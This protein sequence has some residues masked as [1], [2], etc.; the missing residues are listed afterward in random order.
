MLADRCYLRVAWLARDQPRDSGRSGD[1]G[2]GGRAVLRSPRAR[3]KR[4]CGSYRAQ[5][6][7]ITS[8]T[9]LTKALGKT[10]KDFTTFP[11]A[12]TLR[13]QKFH[14]QVMN[15]PVVLPVCSTQSEVMLDCGRGD[16]RVGH[17]HAR[18]QGVLLYID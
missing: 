7:R 14:R 5:Q 12:E 10:Q 3:S 4:P 16:E 15:Q 1:G 6:F 8:D 9:G 17:A 2:R 13:A 18:F 11:L